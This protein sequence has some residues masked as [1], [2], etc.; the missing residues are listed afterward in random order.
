M[1]SLEQTLDYVKLCEHAGESIEPRP[2]DQLIPLLNGLR[3]IEDRDVLSCMVESPKTDTAY[4]EYLRIHSSLIALGVIDEL[5]PIALIN[6]RKFREYIHKLETPQQVREL[7]VKY[8]L[9][10]M[11]DYG[12]FIELARDVHALLKEH[13]ML[14][15]VYNDSHLHRLIELYNYIETKDEKFEAGV[16]YIPEHFRMDVTH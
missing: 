13:D 7:A 11:S 12:V 5:H 8:E 4:M 15:R 2:A 16:R 14:H 6:V 9:Q 3:D 10:D 1:I